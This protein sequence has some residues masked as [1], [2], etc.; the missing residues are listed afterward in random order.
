MF[1]VRVFTFLTLYKEMNY[2]RAA[3]RLRMTQPGVTQHIQRLEQQYGVRFFSYEGRT[4]HRT[5]EAEIFKR[6]L[7]SMLVEEKAMREELLGK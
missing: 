4:L 1:D 2:R 6:Y 3:E 5:R 7:D